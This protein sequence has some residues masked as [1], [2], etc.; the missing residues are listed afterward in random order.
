[1]FETVPQ[2]RSS[3]HTISYVAA[4]AVLSALAGHLGHHRTGTRL[5]SARVLQEEIPAALREALATETEMASW[6]R[7]HLTRRRIWLTGGGPS[8][9]TALEVALKIKEAA[10]AAFA[11]DRGKINDMDF[12]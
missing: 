2:E 10:Y 3:T 8:A 12:A 9:V 6:A 4:I 11:A 1:M 7:A 5:L